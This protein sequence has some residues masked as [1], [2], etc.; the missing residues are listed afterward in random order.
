MFSTDDVV[1]F[2]I[3]SLNDLRKVAAASLAF[4]FSILVVGMK[5]RNCILYPKFFVAV[6][7]F[8]RFAGSGR[9]SD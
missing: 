7:S 6:R 4:M 3:I 2:N 8:F 9:I 5:V 1:D